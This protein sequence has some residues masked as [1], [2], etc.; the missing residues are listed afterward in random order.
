M[1]TYEGFLNELLSEA[2]EADLKRMGAS[3]D[4]IAM[5]KARQAK[6][7][8]GFES[9]DDRVKKSNDIKPQKKLAPS[10][11]ALAKRPADKG[12]DIVATKQ[13]RTGKEAVGVPR[14]HIPQP[15][16]ERGTGTKT[17][18]RMVG[19][20]KPIPNDRAITKTPDQAQQNRNR[21]LNSKKPVQA[22]PLAKKALN[23]TKK[24]AKTAGKIGKAV[25]GAKSGS[26][27][28]VEAKGLGKSATREYG[29]SQY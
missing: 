28:S 15:K 17:Y 21:I 13:E 22:S 16:Q 19:K 18:N 11:G 4:Q 29:D 2:T 8:K 9:G 7:G 26:L 1:K 5:L 10:G 25:I 3:S 20:R 24:I 23:T 6:R 12:R 14:N 27:G